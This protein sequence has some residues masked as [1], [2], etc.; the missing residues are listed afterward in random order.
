MSTPATIIAAAERYAHLRVIEMCRV[1][2]TW[3]SDRPADYRVAW[4]EIQ[5]DWLAYAGDD[6]RSRFVPSAAQI[7][8]ADETMRVIATLKSPTLRR[9]VWLVGFNCLRPDGEERARMPWTAVGNR[10][11]VHADT[12]RRR[13]EEAVRRMS[14][15]F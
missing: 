9:T 4:P 2:K 12:V 13:Y 7:S 15:R 14:S 1:A 3:R 6:R 8:R 5:Q 10:M 11:G